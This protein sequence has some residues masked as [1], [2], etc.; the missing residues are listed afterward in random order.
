MLEFLSIRSIATIP[1]SSLTFSPGLTVVTGETGAGKSLFVDALA[2][3]SGEKPK[4]L[5]V[6]PGQAEGVVEAGFSPLEEVP[7]SFKEL[8]SAGED[9]VIRRMIGENGR[10]RQTVNGHSVS[11]SQ[12]LELGNALIDIV[13]QGESSRLTDSRRHRQFLDSFAR[14]EDLLDSYELLR[15]KRRGL[16]EELSELQRLERET[17]AEQDLLLEKLQDKEQLDPRPGEWKE[18]GDLLSAHRHA[19]ELEGCVGNLLETVYGGEVS[20]LGQLKQL[21]MEVGRLVAH[22]PRLEGFERGLVDATTLLRE[23]AGDARDYLS[24]LEFDPGKALELESRHD[25]YLKLSRKYR[26]APEDV[27]EYFSNL[28]PLEGDNL[29]EKIRSLVCEIDETEEALKE[30]AGLMTARRIEAAERLEPMM[31]ERLLRLKLEHA[32]F[33]VERTALP[34][35]SFPPGGADA[36]RFLF[37]ANPG[38]PPKP[39]DEVASGGEVSRILLVLKWILSDRDQGSSLIFDEVDSGIGGEVGEVLGDLLSD[40]ALNRQVITITHLHQVA[41]KGQTH[42]LVK[43]E[44]FDGVTRSEILPVEGEDRVQEMARMLGGDA[45]S[46]TTRVL[47]R[48]LLKDRLG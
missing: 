22:D 30:L 23:M 26:I 46:P 31:K 34:V 1:E 42:L 4:G 44:S 38:L 47:A 24:R 16:Q 11:Q 39:L 28:T 43:K 17:L 8:L 29:S 32:R 14:V 27:W 2:F 20:I 10:T 36:I 33:L 35:E 48:E 45:M 3:I 40:I 15:L 6:R 7:E 18:I 13:G 41:R 21:E 19:K 5:T 12:L 9:L 25:L 37:S